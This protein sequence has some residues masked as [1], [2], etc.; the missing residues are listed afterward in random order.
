[1]GEQ[2]QQRMKSQRRWASASASEYCGNHVIMQGFKA[3][4]A[5]GF[6]QGGLLKDRRKVLV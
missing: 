2:L 6:F 3:Y 4:F 1:M 5:L